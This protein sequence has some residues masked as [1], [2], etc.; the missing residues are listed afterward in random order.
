MV[1]A[2]ELSFSWSS[3]E[4]ALPRLLQSL[5]NSTNTSEESRVRLF[6]KERIKE[7]SAE[8]E[9]DEILS[10]TKTPSKLPSY[11]VQTT[12]RFFSFVINTNAYA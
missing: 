3:E 6:F 7:S 5:T 8:D 10:K 1:L 4:I 11:R 12:Q 2:Q 9:S